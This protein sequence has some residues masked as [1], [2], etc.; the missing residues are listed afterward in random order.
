MALRFLHMQHGASQVRDGGTRITLAV[1]RLHGRHCSWDGGGYALTS[2]GGASQKCFERGHGTA[3]TGLRQVPVVVA[4]PH[5]SCLRQSQVKIGLVTGDGKKTR[6]SC[7]SPGHA[8]C[9]GTYTCP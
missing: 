1:A 8:V 7:I 4:H 3:A 5:V 6:S 9:S 2:H